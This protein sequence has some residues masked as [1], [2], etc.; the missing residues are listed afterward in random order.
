MPNRVWKQADAPPKDSGTPI[1]QCGR[2]SGVL[3]D[4]RGKGDKVYPQ[5]GEN[6]NMGIYGGK[7]GVSQ[8]TPR[9]SPIV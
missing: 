8:E 2:K 9:G 3:S 1:N 6:R 5:S 7:S 4:F